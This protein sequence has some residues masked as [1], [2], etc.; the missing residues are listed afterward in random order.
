MSVE[1][2]EN[3]F[4]LPVYRRMRDFVVLSIVVVRATLDSPRTARDIVSTPMADMHPFLWFLS[5]MTCIS[6][7][8][9]S[10]VSPAVAG[11]PGGGGGVEGETLGVWKGRRWVREGRRWVWEGRR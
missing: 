5:S 3:K 8:S 6:A 10:H 2:S 1:K 4:I 11:S 7:Y 9:A